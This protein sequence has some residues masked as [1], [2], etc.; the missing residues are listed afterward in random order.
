MSYLARRLDRARL[1]VIGTYRPV[2]VIVG[3]HPLKGVK[4][5]LQAHNLCRELPLEYL[6]EEAV[7]EYLNTRFPGHQLPARLRR[8]IYQRTEGNPLF[9]VNLV[10]YLIDQKMIVE[11]RG[12]WNLRVELSD[13]EKGVPT[14]LRQLIEKQIERLDPDQRTVLEAASVAGMECSSI[15]IA[16][17][18]DMPIASVE[19]RCEELAGRHQFLSPA[20]LVELPDGTI[21]PRHRF[22]HVLYRDVPY[23]MMAPMR[24]SQIHQRIAE[25]G[26]VI[27]GDHCSEIAAELAMHFEQSRDWPHA[28]EYLLKAAENAAA[29]SA[30]HEA[31]D[32]ANRGLEIL[33]SLPRT[34]THSKDEMKLRMILSVSLMTIKGF[35]SEEVESINARGR[36]L[37]W[38]LGPSPELFYMLWSL[39]LYYQFSGKLQSALEISSQLLQLAEDLNDGALLMAAHRAM[40]AALVEIGRCTEAL[41]HL[42]AGTALYATHRQ[43]PYDVFMG[44]DCK[45]V[46]EC[47]AA[48]ALWALGY[49]D[50]AAEKIASAL[51]L[52]RD[53]A[54]PQTLMVVG[55]FAVQLHQLLREPQLAQQHARAVVKLADEYGLE[56]WACFGNID[57]AW[58]DAELGDAQRG[59]AQMKR[60]LEAYEATGARLRCP[61]FLGLLADEL[62]K[63]GH[64]LEGL[65][66]IAKALTLAER[67][68]ERYWLAELHRIKG[69]LII[70]HCDLVQQ[71]NVEDGST[72][73]VNNEISQMLLQAEACFAQALAIAKQQGTKSWELRTALS[74]NR[75]QV[76]QGEPTNTHLAELFSSFTEGHETADL[77]QAKA[78]LNATVLA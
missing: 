16:A 49:P 72:S 3:D 78:W 8:T 68:G 69:E 5:E 51:A 4:R 12:A 32:L 22:I 11:E 71:E 47:L 56:V 30:H 44:R 24:R 18:L 42:D 26:V 10:E 39:G 58:S 37:F 67:N 63:A 66:A 77:R 70:K 14:N 45:V 43:H 61:Y 53:L 29:C 23:R 21:T 19:E 1:L 73:R 27:Y 52:A 55:H 15:A 33:K 50:R 59:I 76:R 13:I 36:E 2:D 6:A 20:W 38:Q 17:G 7:A 34:S 48:R 75:L 54:H 60:S 57:L 28:L 35:A 46:C 74:M 64:V 9:M 41:H 31:S 65:A 40:G 25:R 62:G